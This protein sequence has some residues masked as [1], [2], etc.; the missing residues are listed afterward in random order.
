MDAAIAITV[1]LYQLYWQHQERY[2]LHD[3][4]GKW[5]YVTST[6][7]PDPEDPSH[8]HSSFL[9]ALSAVPSIV[10][11]AIFV[12]VGH[13]SA[14][15]LFWKDYNLYKSRA[16]PSDMCATIVRTSQ[17]SCTV[18][19]YPSDHEAFATLHNDK[20][21]PGEFYVFSKAEPSDADDAMND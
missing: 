18:T 4:I 19:W 7:Q 3:R 10:S 1:K 9:A 16:S 2:L 12:R 14:K 13:E 6:E 11:D 5:V 15:D 20:S 8:F 21:A 17:T